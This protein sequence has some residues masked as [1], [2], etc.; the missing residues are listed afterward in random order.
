MLQCNFSNKISMPKLPELQLPVALS[1]QRTKHSRAG[2]QRRGAVSGTASRGRAWPAPDHMGPGPPPLG[3]GNPHLPGRSRVPFETWP[4]FLICIS[5]ERVQQRFSVF[6]ICP[7]FL[8]L[9]FKNDSA[10]PY[11]IVS[12][13]LEVSYTT[14]SSFRVKNTLKVNAS[15]LNITIQCLVKT[16]FSKARRGS[17]VETHSQSA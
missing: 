6:C 8:T 15:S 12:F 2:L 3:P 10:K 16:I 11:E 5:K 17:E 4:G 7:C 1:T 14:M 9:S 13:L